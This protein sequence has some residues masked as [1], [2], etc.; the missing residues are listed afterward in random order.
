MLKFLAGL[1]CGI[2]LGLLI[3][4]AA[5]SE[6][7]ERL[8]DQLEDRGLPVR[9]SVEQLK[10]VGQEKLSDLRDKASDMGLPVG[11]KEPVG[12]NLGDVTIY[13]KD[14]TA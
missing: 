11:G 9:D 7:R 8:L 6:T 5:G 13:R 1:G 10:R 2:G 3:A 14:R 12:E 4:P